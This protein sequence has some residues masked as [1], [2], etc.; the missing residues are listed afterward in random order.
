MIKNH[1]NKSILIFLNIVLVLTAVHFSWS[2]SANLQKEQTKAELDMFCTT[3]E[4]MKLQ[5]YSTRRDKKNAFKEVICI[6]S[7]MG[8][9]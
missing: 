2:H 5:A 9:S 6:G 1:I 8:K 7:F 4:S 3:I